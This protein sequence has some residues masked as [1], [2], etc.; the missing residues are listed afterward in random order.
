MLKIGWASADVST[1]EPIAIVGQGHERISTGSV[2]PTTITALYLEDGGDYVLFL[3]GDFTSMETALLLE[4]KAL[5]AEKLPDFNSDKL[6]LNA[7]HTHTA[8]RFSLKRG[9][10]KAPK[11]RV[12]I[13]PHEKYR[14]FLLEQMVKI[15]MDAVQGAAE[16]SVSYGYDFASVGFSRRSTYFHDR[17]ANNAKGNTFAVNGHAAM[18]GKTNDPDFSGFEGS[19][20]PYVYSLYTF[21]AAGKLTGALVNVACPS[22]C[23]EHDSFTSAD[24]WNE[25][26]E[27]IRRDFGNIYILP[28]CAAAG[29]LSPHI[30]HNQDARLRKHL[31]RY[32][33]DPKAQLF[34]RPFEYYSRREIG[35][36]IAQAVKNGYG[37]A[38]N[39]KLTTMPITH[40]TEVL[41]LERWNI[42]QQQYEEAKENLANLE[43]GTWQV[44]DDPMADFKVNTRRSSELSRC[45]GVI[46]RYENRS[47]TAPVEIHVLKVG[48][49][50]FVTCPFELYIDYQ[51][52]LQA[53]SPFPQTFMVQLV[54]TT[55]GTAGYLATERAAANKGYSA[56]SY[57]CQIAPKGG[58]AMIERMLE[59]LEQIQA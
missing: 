30:L 53:R 28:Q 20:D 57:S 50:A 40:V 17:G 49:I 48:P 11:D 14:A 5:L 46:S 41:E 51:H 18:Y 44:T 36:R 29:D 45:E 9:Y 47:E 16:G 26:R 15:I 56:I 13:Y 54:A 35:E 27:A 38:S 32:G 6:I 23:T 10:D 2:D 31:L 52:R 42:T 21:D 43:Q 37:W 58:Q 3:S 22:Q 34:V 19:L 55:T 39:E 7:T 24:F 4:L 1:N 59:I 12:T 33:E 25:A 8:P